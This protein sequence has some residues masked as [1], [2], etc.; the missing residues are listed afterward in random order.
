MKNIVDKF[1]TLIRRL[2]YSQLRLYDLNAARIEEWCKENMPLVVEELKDLEW[3]LS[4]DETWY[5]TVFINTTVHWFG[6]RIALYITSSAADFRLASRL[7]KTK[8]FAKLRKD[9]NFDTHAV[10]LLD[11]TIFL[12]P[13][14]LDSIYL[15]FDFDKKYSSLDFSHYDEDDNIEEAYIPEW[16]WLTFDEN[17]SEGWSVIQIEQAYKDE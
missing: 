10:V 6:K 4:V 11:T 17:T 15:S 12:Q 16:G 5:E 3:D 7:F 9:F 2:R 8:A 1:H 13:E 14:D